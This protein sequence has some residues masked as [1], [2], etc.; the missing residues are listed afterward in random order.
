MEKIASYLFDLIDRIYIKK[1]NSRFILNE[2]KRKNIF[3]F[4]L[5]LLFH[6]FFNSS[7]NIFIYLSK[8]LYYILLFCTYI[9]L[10]ISILHLMIFKTYSIHSA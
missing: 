10:A 4:Y 1:E 8:T 2:R 3:T 5:N 6:V 9:F 7:N